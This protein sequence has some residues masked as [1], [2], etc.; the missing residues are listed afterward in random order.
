MKINKELFEYGEGDGRDDGL[1]TYIIPLIKCKYSKNQIRVIFEL[2]NKYIFRTPLL[3][4]ELDKM[5]D[6]NELF[7][8]TINFYEKGQFFTR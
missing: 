6:N 4:R 3:Q 8:E 2:I 7:D 1:F 5:F